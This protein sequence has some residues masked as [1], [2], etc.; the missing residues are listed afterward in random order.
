MITVFN[1]SCPLPKVII[2]KVDYSAE[3][4][5][6]GRWGS[7]SRVGV[8][9]RL[10]SSCELSVNLLRIVFRSLIRLYNILNRLKDMVSTNHFS[11]AVSIQLIHHRLYYFA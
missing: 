11:Y 7:F 1:I 2:E 6:I 4:K 3:I 9:Y 8:N 10:V 5:G